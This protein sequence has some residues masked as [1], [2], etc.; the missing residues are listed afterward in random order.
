MKEKYYIVLEEYERRMIINS[1]NEL[2]NRLIADGRYTEAVD[3]ILLKIINA[4]KKKF[5]VI[6]KEA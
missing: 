5:K 4:K 6:C 2:R 1:L 3:E